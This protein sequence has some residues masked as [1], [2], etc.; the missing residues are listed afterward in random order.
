M[1]FSF[2]TS[3]STSLIFIFL[4]KILKLELS[5]IFETVE[6]FLIV[7]LSQIIESM[8]ILFVPTVQLLPM[9][10]SGPIIES[11]PYFSVFTNITGAIILVRSW[12]LVFS[13]INMP[14]FSSLNSDQRT[15]LHL[16]YPHWLEHIFQLYLCPSNMH[17]FYKLQ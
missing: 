13:P 17:H 8:I 11:G 9:I 4:L 14:W 3:I 16:K 6:L 7:I 2:K 15:G 10:A 12:Y 1:I 5:I